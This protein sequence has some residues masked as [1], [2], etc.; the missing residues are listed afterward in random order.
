MDAF[1]LTRGGSTADLSWDL[2]GTNEL[3]ST[4]NP[5]PK[6]VSNFGSQQAKQRVP[7]IRR[8][9]DTP[10][11]GAHEVVPPAPGQRGLPEARRSALRRSADMG[12]W[13][14]LDAVKKIMWSFKGIVGIAAFFWWFWDLSFKGRV[15]MVM[16]VVLWCFGKEVTLLCLKV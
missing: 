1:P 4:L 8:L 11:H 10:S 2:L 7:P 13:N 3:I 15:G 14:P 5:K 16:V 12:P 6:E 9:S